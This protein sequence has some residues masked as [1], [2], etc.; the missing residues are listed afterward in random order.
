MRFE[1]VYVDDGSHPCCEVDSRPHD[2]LPALGNG[3]PGGWLLRRGVVYDPPAAPVVPN[4]LQG[5]H[6]LVPAILLGPPHGA[7]RRFLR[8]NSLVLTRQRAGISMVRLVRLQRRQRAVGTEVP[9]SPPG[10]FRPPPPRPQVSGWPADVMS[11]GGSTCFHQSGLA[12]ESWSAWWR[13]RQRRHVQPGGGIGA[14]ACCC[15]SVVCSLLECSAMMTRWT[16][17]IHG[18]GNLRCSPGVLRNRAGVTS[19]QFARFGSR[20]WGWRGGGV[21]PGRRSSLSACCPADD[22]GAGTARKTSRRA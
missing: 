12:S 14:S 11:S 17:G 19:G 1:I 6:A 20:R 9:V 2:P 16:P 10:R 5:S 7:V 15:A 22:D 13:S 18:L 3:V 4:S 21:Q 8:P